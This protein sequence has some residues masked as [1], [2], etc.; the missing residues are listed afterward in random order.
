MVEEPREPRWMGEGRAELE[1]RRA[2]RHP[3]VR[4]AKNAGGQTGRTRGAIEG[5]VAAGAG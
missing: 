2:R 3:A 1:A 5:E 4:R